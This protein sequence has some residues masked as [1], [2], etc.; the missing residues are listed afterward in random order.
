MSTPN[1][2]KLPGA[3][4]ERIAPLAVADGKTLHVWI[5]EALERQVEFSE[6]RESFIRDAEASAAEVDAGGDLYAAKRVVSYLNA[7][8]AGKRCVARPKAR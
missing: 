7:L 1:R 3:L 8:A 6:A 4:K 2:I 5:V